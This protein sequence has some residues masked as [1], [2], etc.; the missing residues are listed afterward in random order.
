MACVLLWRPANTD[1][2]PKRCLLSFAGDSAK[3]W[4][5]ASTKADPFARS[6][7]HAGPSSSVVGYS[8]DDDGSDGGG[9]DD[10]APR[11]RGDKPSGSARKQSSVRGQS[12]SGS[13]PT[14]G[15]KADPFA[16]SAA[17]KYSKHQ[18]GGGDEYSAAI[19]TL[20]QTGASGNAKGQVCVPVCPC[21]RVP[22]ACANAM[23]ALGTT[24]CVA[25]RVHA[26]P[27][28]SVASVVAEA[29]AAILRNP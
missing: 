11:K 13:R 1:N 3:S 21:T 9:G 19:E 23:L 7:K 26:A 18:A 27:F 29:A 2:P 14:A 8:D 25:R 24:A 6:P 5:A 12:R 28:C 20:A 4:V 22:L 10:P 17:Q 15:S 16:R